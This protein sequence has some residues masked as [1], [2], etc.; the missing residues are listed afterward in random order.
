MFIDCHQRYSHTLSFTG[1]G[2]WFVEESVSSCCPFLPPLCAFQDNT[3][4]IFIETLPSWQL[5]LPSAHLSASLT[6]WILRC[7]QRKPGR[8]Y[9]RVAGCRDGYLRRQHKQ[10]CEAWAALCVSESCGSSSSPITPALLNQCEHHSMLMQKVSV[11]GIRPSPSLS[12]HSRNS[13]AMKWWIACL[14]AQEKDAALSESWLYWPPASCIVGV[15]WQ[16]SLWWLN[17]SKS[18]GN[19]APN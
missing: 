15:W 16:P 12:S 3:W 8:G 18:H 9:Q 7:K 4:V 5:G 17:S 19:N 13:P 6:M 11:A 2:C 1:E 10:T 14:I